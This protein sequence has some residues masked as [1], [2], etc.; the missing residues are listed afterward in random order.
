VLVVG[1]MRM[2]HDGRSIWADGVGKV[3][4]SLDTCMLTN[5]IMVGTTFL[6][7]FLYCCKRFKDSK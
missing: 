4:F 5:N 6:A 7:S 1:R 2:V 3:I